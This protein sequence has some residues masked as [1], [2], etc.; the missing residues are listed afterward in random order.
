VSGPA[1]R[2]SDIGRNTK[3]KKLFADSLLEN[4]VTRE[5]LRVA[6]AAAGDMSAQILAAG[7]PLRRPRYLEGYW[8]ATR[9]SAMLRPKRRACH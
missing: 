7:D 3:R 9:G 6:V 1:V 8:R 5:A 2:G 4:E